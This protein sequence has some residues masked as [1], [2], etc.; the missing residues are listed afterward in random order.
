MN[1]K[2]FKEFTLEQYGLLLDFRTHVYLENY[3]GC[4]P[5]YKYPVAETVVNSFFAFLDKHNVNY[6]MRYNKD[7]MINELRSTPLK[8]MV[9][10]WLDLEMH[11][12]Y[13]AELQDRNSY[14]QAEKISASSLADA[15]RIALSK[16]YFQG[17]VI[18][19]GANVSDDGFILNPTCVH[20]NGRWDY[21][22]ENNQ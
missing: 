1:I 2:K 18:E 17:T 7:Q 10:Y 12:Y 4:N 20:E 3:Y 22:G 8:H 14:R 15:Q 6:A 19:I 9:S 21:V 5:Q 13:S 16:Q 11:T